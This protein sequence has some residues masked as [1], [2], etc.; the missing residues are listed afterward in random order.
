MIRNHKVDKSLS[1]KKNYKHLGSFYTSHLLNEQ[2]KSSN[3]F[4]SKLTTPM[5]RVMI[6]NA[7]VFASKHLI[8]KRIVSSI[9]VYLFIYHED[10][11]FSML[12]YYNNCRYT[13]SYDYY[14]NGL[15]LK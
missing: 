9:F 11:I 12:M 5:I 10:N 2:A 14:D 13:M 8:I 1:D 7:P 15:N 4:M 3:F 6:K